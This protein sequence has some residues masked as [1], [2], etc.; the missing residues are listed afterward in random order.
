MLSA[1]AVLYHCAL[2]PPS[3]NVTALQREDESAL[4]Q[5]RALLPS[6]PLHPTHPNTAPGAHWWWWWWALDKKDWGG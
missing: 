4:L 6:S 3:P 1:D 2:P 5:R